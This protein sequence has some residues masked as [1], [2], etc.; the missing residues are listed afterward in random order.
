MLLVAGFGNRAQRCVCGFVM[1]RRDRDGARAYADLATEFSTAINMDG[2]GTHRTLDMPLAEH[3]KARL[4]QQRSTKNSTHNDAVGMNWKR[5]NHFCTAG[6]QQFV[7]V[8]FEGIISFPVKCNF[9]FA[10]Q[11][12]RDHSD[13]HCAAANCERCEQIA[14]FFNTQGPPRVDSAGDM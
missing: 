9:S 3:L 6:Y 1:G 2:T 11:R 14:F 8:N 12:T 4:N 5:T 10:P 13:D 7:G